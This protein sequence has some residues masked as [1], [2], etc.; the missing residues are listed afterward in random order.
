MQ[1]TYQSVLETS[2]KES[3]Y[4]I[5]IYI[6]VHISEDFVWSPQN[7]IRGIVKRA[8]LLG[9]VQNFYETCTT[10]MKRAELLWNV[11]NFYETCRTSMKRAELLWNVHNFYETCRTSMK[12]AQLLWNVHNTW[13]HWVGAVK[14]CIHIFPKKLY[15]YTCIYI[16]ITHICMCTCKQ[17]KD[18]QHV[19]TS[20]VFV[21]RIRN[22]TWYLGQCKVF[23]SATV[24]PGFSGGQWASVSDTLRRIIRQHWH[25]IYPCTR[26]SWP[27]K[28]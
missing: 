10:S 13:K 5:H 9:N 27:H 25:L 26:F 19:N 22:E 21:E 12:R 15:I 28:L 11:Q 2:S 4:N 6:Y 1:S 17:H 7:V 8:Q 18:H 3:T 24:H 20:L 14:Q 23:L 16:Y